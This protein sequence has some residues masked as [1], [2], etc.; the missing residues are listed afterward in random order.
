ML[1]HKIKTGS[2]ATDNL[3]YAQG[4]KI[5]ISNCCHKSYSAFCIVA[6]KSVTQHGKGAGP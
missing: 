3:G 1:D 4:N 2:L 6:A 5:S